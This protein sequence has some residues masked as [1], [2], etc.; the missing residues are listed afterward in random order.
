MHA[1]DIITIVSAD[2]INEQHRLAMSYAG[3]AFEHA[4]RAGELLQKVKARLKHGEFL[5]WLEAHVEVTPRQAQR[6][7]AAAAGKP[8]PARAVKCDTVSSLPR[9]QAAFEPVAS[10]SMMVQHAGRVFIVEQSDQADFFF[11]TMLMLAGDDDAIVEY[12]RSPIRSDYTELPLQQMGLDD[13]S[14]ATWTIGRNCR[15]QSALGGQRQFGVTP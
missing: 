6:Y 3:R 10:C 11:V 15:V 5:P 8:L 13:P 7:M 4:R 1:A 12:L 2:E 9:R 14:C